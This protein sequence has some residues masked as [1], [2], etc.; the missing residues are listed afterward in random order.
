MADMALLARSIPRTRAFKGAKIVFR[1]HSA[2][3]DCVVRDLSESGARLAFP[4]SL[5]IPETFD[6]AIP[7]MS[8]R[9]CRLVWRKAS[10]IGVMFL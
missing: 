10:Q 2:T 5:G 7:G 1:E 3:L 4:S 8:P 9:R 6:L